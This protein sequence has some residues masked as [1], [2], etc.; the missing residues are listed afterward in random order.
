MLRLLPEISFLLISTLPVHAPAFFS[1]PL[2][3]FH[4][5]AVANTGSS[6]DPQNEIGHPACRRQRQMCIRDRL[7]A[8]KGE[9]LSFVF[10]PDGTLIS[11]SAA[12]HCGEQTA[13]P[14]TQ[15]CVSLFY[16]HKPA[17]SVS[18]PILIGASNQ[19]CRLVVVSFC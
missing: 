3:V 14:C 18:L 9:P 16:I 4:V 7:Q 13:R 6:V 8:I 11:A 17:L 1:K 5:L 12:P 2:P 19:T 10:S 15:S